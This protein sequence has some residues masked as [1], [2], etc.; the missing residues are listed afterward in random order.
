M[1]SVRACV[2]VPKSSSRTVKVSCARSKA[3]SPGDLATVNVSVTATARA[4]GKVRLS[5]VVTT[6]G[7]ERTVTRTFRI[8]PSGSCSRKGGSK[9][10]SSGGQFCGTTNHF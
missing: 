1:N 9:G 8:L 4:K 2:T 5:L 3:V 6:D 7:G 10:G